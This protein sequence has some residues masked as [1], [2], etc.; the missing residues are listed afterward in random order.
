MD[1]VT[2]TLISVLVGEAVHRS[3]PP[4]AVLSDRARR[5]VAITVMAVGGN[6]PDADVIYTSWAGSTLDYLLHHRGHTHTVLGALGLSLVLFLA[7]RLWWRYRGVTPGRADLG[8]L[9]GLAVLAP[10][11]HIGLDFTN[12]YGVHPFWPVDNRWYY[13]DSVFIVEPLLWACAAALLFV[14]PSRTLRVLIA[15]VLA[16]GLGLSWF[17]GFVPPSFAALLTALT[18]GLVAV[19]RFASARAALASSV[20][21]WLALTAAFVVTAR[22]AESRFGD[23]LADRFP[24]ART[25]D[26]VLTPMPANPVCRE[27]LA[28]QRT[29]DRYVVRRAFHSLA[30]GWIAADRCADLYPTSG[31]GTAPLTPVAQPST[32]EVSWTGELSVPVDLLATLATEYCAVDALLQFARAPVATPV[33]DGWIVGDLRYDREP[34]LGL[35]E[36]GVGPSEDGCPRLRA[37]WTPPRED[38][39]G[40]D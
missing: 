31:E 9:A 21:A 27:V 16:A 12:S 20:A 33:G 5:T 10:L 19:S 4:S 23:L 13:G 17:S 11:L 3:I 14:L 6:L 29:S 35:A 7:V 15:V 2:H 24:Q 28:V 34:G 25:L 32:D 36:V 18:V 1:N 26:V 8:F 22:S 39:L 37:P 38:L 40:G 30:P